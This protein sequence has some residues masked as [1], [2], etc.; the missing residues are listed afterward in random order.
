M[1]CALIEVM[2]RVLPLLTFLLAFF[3]TQA[4]IG[5]NSYIQN[6]S[7]NPAVS[8]Q[9]DVP[10]ENASDDFSPDERELS[11]CFEIGEVGIHILRMKVQRTVSSVKFIFNEFSEI[12]WHI[13]FDLERPP[14]HS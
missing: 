7:C 3:I 9:C 13:I 14:K 4:E 12:A 11:S 10:D 2:F 1:L 6:V 8:E 5:F